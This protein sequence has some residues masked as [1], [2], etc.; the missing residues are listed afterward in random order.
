MNEYKTDWEQL[1]RDEF[2]P[3]DT[4]QPDSHM[5]QAVTELPIKPCPVLDI[6]CGTG[7]SSIWLAL[8]GFKVTGV[9]ISET[10]I[11]TSR[12]KPGGKR[13][14]FITMDFLKAPAL[15]KDFG[16]VFDMGCFHVFHEEEEREQFAKKVAECLLDNSL[17]L[18]ISGSC[19]G[20]EYGPPRL[21]AIEI[22]KAVE[23]YFEILYLKA[24][25]I[26]KLT[27]EELE[28]LGLPPGT[29][30]KAWECLMR[31]RCGTVAE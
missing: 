13:C 20:P 19:D 16:F 1:Y 28:T 30:P 27:S 12:A 6:G 11:Q 3:W 31:K 9:D 4:G 17:W 25:E 14:T 21:S 23:P 18:S 8:H 10:A 22:S 5:I 26:D 15:R 29:T 7:E 24:S 2:T